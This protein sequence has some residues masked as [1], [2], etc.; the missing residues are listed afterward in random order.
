MRLGAFILL[1]AGCPVG[2][3]AVEPISLEQAI[4]E[5]I[6]NNMELVAERFSLSVSEARQITA[7]LR[8][9]PI[10]TVQAQS[11]ELLGTRFIPASPAGPNQFNV[12][13]DY[14]MERGHKRQQRIAFAAEDRRLVDLQ[15]RELTRRLILDL[16]AGFV[17]VQQ[18]RL[19]G[20][21]A[22]QNLKSLQGIV[23]VNENR[24]RTGDLAEVE[25]DRSR[26]AVLQYETAVA[27][28]R[29]ALEQARTRLQRLM[30][31]R[32]TSADFDV[33]GDLRRETKKETAEAIVL[34][35]LERRPD[36]AALKQAEI[37]SRADLKL[38]LANGRVDYLLGAEYTYQRAFGFGGPSL[39]FSFSAPLPV[40]NKNQGEI[41]RAQ[42]EGRQWESRGSALETGIRSEVEL[43][44]R[45]YETTGGLLKNI[46]MNLLT[47]AQKVRDVTE[48]SY[49][50][51]EATLIEFLDAQRAFNDAVQSH[52][53][54]R[55]SHARS[56]YLLDAVAAD[57]IEK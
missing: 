37:R 22:G 54:A 50:R 46:E 48:Y 23:T 19:A 29:L 32:T 2:A 12:H 44:Y 43:A 6:A 45:Q 5:A 27:Q 13:T 7:A 40:F 1:L 9:N 38:Q 4:Q 14:V 57:T 25:L 52:N 8:P 42:R 20:L 24:V 15:I 39:G 34:R 31:R 17:D 55:A 10:L 41:A 33:S 11:L 51:G 28:S 35:A 49:R 47:R 18:A 56:L 53:E 3:L 16:Q 21:L 36:L 30:G 26:V